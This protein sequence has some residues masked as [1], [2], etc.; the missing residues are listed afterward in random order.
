MAKTPK[1]FSEVFNA[2]QARLAREEAKAQAQVAERQR[3][4]SI[5]QANPE[6]GVLQGEKGVRYYVNFPTYREATDPA[7]LV[8]AK[9]ERFN[10]AADHYVVTVDGEEMIRLNGNVWDGKRSFALAVEAEPGAQMI[11]LDVYRARLGCSL[12]QAVHVRG[13]GSAYRAI[14]ALSGRKEA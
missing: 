5:L 3:I 12:R 11:T 6:I 13:A 10:P 2:R 14:S 4:E 1:T 9:L 7:A 8:G